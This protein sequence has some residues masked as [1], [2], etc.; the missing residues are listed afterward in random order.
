[1][2]KYP[3]IYVA[4]MEGCAACEAAKPEI[5]RFAARLDSRIQVRFVDISK[6]EQFPAPVAAVPAVI[7]TVPGVPKA[8]QFAQDIRV[9]ESALVSWINEAVEEFKQLRSAR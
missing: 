5:Q 4:V 1:M 8:H 3:V 6:G 9:T 2:S 7:L